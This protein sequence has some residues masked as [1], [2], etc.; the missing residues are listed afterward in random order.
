MSSIIK[1]MTAVPTY[2]TGTND[3]DLPSV[4]KLSIEETGKCHPGGF[5][6]TKE[7][8]MQVTVGVN[9]WANQA[10]YSSGC[11]QAEK[12][13]LQVIHADILG[14]S[15]AIRSAIMSGDAK[16]A[17]SYVDQINKRLGL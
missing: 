17:L 6:E 16:T 7:Y 2:M 13:L 9:F 10:E 4:N 3:F 1:K 14:I 12:R 8:V 5:S 15:D 11:S